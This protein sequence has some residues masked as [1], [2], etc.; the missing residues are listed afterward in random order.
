MSDV[1]YD[2]LRYREGGFN[3]ADRLFS[4]VANQQAGRRLASGDATGAANTLLR[5]GDLRGGEALQDRQRADQERQRAEQ[6][7]LKAQQVQTTLQVVRAMRQVRDQ[8]GDIATEIPKYRGV[9]EALGVPGQEYDATAA[10]LAANPAFLDQA[11]VV[12]GQQARN[13]EVVNFGSGR[14]ASVVDLDSGA[15]VRRLSP[16]AQPI[17]NN[18][19]IRD[20]VTFEVIA[21]DRDPEYIQRDPTKQLLD[22][23]P[24]AGGASGGGRTNPDAI[25]EGVLERE[26]GFVASDGRSGAP[27]NFGINQ[28]A[29]PDIDVRNLTREGAKAIYQDRY[30]NPILQAGVS[31]PILEAVVDFGVNA[32]VNRSLDFWRRSGGDINEFN[33]LRL[34]HYRSLPD[35]EQNG[36][37]WERRVR[38]TTPGSTGSVSTGGGP[39]VVS[40]A[41]APVNG[42]GIL[43]PQEQAAL[44]LPPTGRY[45]RNSAG[46]IELVAGTALAG[47][48]SQGNPTEAQNKDSFNA[49]RMTRAGEEVRRLEQEGFD[50]GR[51]QLGGQL[52]GNFRIYDTAAEEWTDSILRLT[53][54]AAA[55]ADEIAS[56]RRAYFPVVG[57]DARVRAAKAER[58]RAVER[59]ALARGQGGRSSVNAPGATPAPVTGTQRRRPTWLTPQQ[60]EFYRNNPPPAGAETGTRAYPLAV[61]RSSP[62]TERTSLANIRPGQWFVPPNSSSPVQMPNPNPFRTRENRRPR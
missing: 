4:G 16:D 17:I 51:A 45:Q 41:Q 53:T 60:L 57:D 34:A 43:S 47:G 6:D 37:S 38:E 9:F 56:N 21:D 1:G 31:G 5:S 26:G 13:L 52:T 28:R 36:R 62:E 46:T 25:L 61:N 33:R 23:S 15:E 10:Q 8:G 29:N 11:E 18:N 35:Y 2:P 49:N 3:Y 12:L 14:G 19:V 42:A 48:A 44:G 50:Y 58:R 20:P 40:E 30:I 55:T 39:R 7:R 22:V 59:D 32:G 27:A 54:G 24:A